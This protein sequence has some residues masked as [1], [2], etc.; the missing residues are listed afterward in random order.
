MIA[1]L[2]ILIL[3]TTKLLDK[4]AP[5]AIKINVNKIVSVSSVRPGVKF[6]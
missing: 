4:S 2:F 1:A 3:K 6:A 5:I